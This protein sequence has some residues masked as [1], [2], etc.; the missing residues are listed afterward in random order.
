MIVQ[1]NKVPDTMFYSVTMVRDIRQ[2]SF[3]DRKA[4]KRRS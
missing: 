1:F 3:I 2:A 4:K